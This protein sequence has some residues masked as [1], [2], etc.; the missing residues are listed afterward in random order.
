M[1]NVDIQRGQIEDFGD[2]ASQITKIDGHGRSKWTT[3]AFNEGEI[4]KYSEPMKILE[5]L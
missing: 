4:V 3:W 1:V 5:I 2:F